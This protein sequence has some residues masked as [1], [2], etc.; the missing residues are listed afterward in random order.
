MDIILVVHTEPGYVVDKQIIYDKDHI[1]GFIEGSKNLSKLCDKYGA[2]I[3]FAVCPEIIN[4]FP[5]NLEH[6]IGLHI[7]PGWLKASR[8]IKGKDHFWYVGDSLL[9]EE[10]NISNK[11]TFLKDYSYE[12]Q[13]KMIRLGKELISTVFNKDPKVFVAG[14]WSLNNDTI[15]ALL[16]EGFTHECSAVANSKSKNFDYSNLNRICMPYNPSPANYQREG[17]LP[18]LMVPIS[19][20]INSVIVNPEVIPHYGISWLKAC[21]LEYYKQGAPLFHICVH[22]P[23]LTDCN[24]IEY[25][26]DL[27]SFISKHEISFK[28]ASEIKKYPEYNSYS[29]VLPYVTRINKNLLKTCYLDL[30]SRI[31]GNL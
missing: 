19:K 25:M 23:C 30:K 1:E 16:A 3:T 20:M 9:R 31:R 17:N 2:K 10:M 6:E 4:D 29:D 18:I 15:K 13:L 22:S 8:T 5:K 28:F 21:F 27:L 26:D 11:S 7:H 24:F 12:E 14:R